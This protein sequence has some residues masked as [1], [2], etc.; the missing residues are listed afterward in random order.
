LFFENTFLIKMAQAKP[1]IVLLPKSF[2]ESFPQEQKN[3]GNT[4]WKT[5]FS[6][7]LSAG[8]A[9][10]PPLASASCPSE[11]QSSS[12]SSPGILSRHKHV[13]PELYHILSGSG[14][15]EISG[16]RH[17]VG[18]GTTVFIPGDAEHAVFNFGTEEL[19]W[20]YVFPGQFEDVIYRFRDEDYGKAKL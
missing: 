4:T 13:Q 6:S 11:P 18:P 19:K 9:S 15:V 17:E 2:P 12:S 20:L 5:L 7:S 1:E 8:I 3:R 16:V 14:T 10:C